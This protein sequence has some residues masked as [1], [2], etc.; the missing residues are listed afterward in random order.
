MT[1]PPTRSAAVPR[2]LTI[3][4]LVAMVVLALV[5]LSGF[6]YESGDRVYQY[7]VAEAIVGAATTAAAIWWIVVARSKGAAVAVLVVSILINPI[8]LLLLIRAFG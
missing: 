8:W 5:A 7:F 4:G 3:V 1:E 2:T 6:T